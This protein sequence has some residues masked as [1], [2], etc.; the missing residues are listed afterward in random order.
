M[1]DYSFGYGGIGSGLDI[2]TMVTQLVAADR[3]PQDARLNKLEANAK[4]KLSGLGTVTSAFDA[5]KTALDTLQK[6]DALAA[7]T[8]TSSSSGGSSGQGGTDTVLAASVG[9]STPTGT[10]QVEVLSLASAH[11]LVGAGVETGTSF[12]AGTLQV[13]IGDASVDVEIAAGATLADVRSAINAAA[14]KHGLQA[15][16]LT[17]DDGQHLSL[18]SAKSGAASAITVSVLSGDDGLQAVV[19]GLQEKSPASDARVAIDGL[20]TTSSSN[21]VADAVPGLTLKLK[22]TGTSSVVVGADPSGSRAAVEGF[23]KAYNAALNAVATATSYNAETKTPSSLTGDAQMR[24]AVAQLRGVMGD[25]LGT[26]AAQGLDART[27]GLQTQGHPN[28]NGNLV[29]DAAKFDAAMTDNAAKIIA[30]FT[31]EDGVAARLNNVVKTYV[32]SDGSLTLRK[33]GLDDQ[34][35]D[36][37]RQR[38]ALELRMSAAAARYKAQFVALDT[39]MGQMTTT[40]NYLAQQI[41]ALAAQTQSR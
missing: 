18:A 33:K 36:V 1:A 34:V 15:S 5:L 27:L 6:A 22:G 40:S 3:A 35:K 13:G 14:G 24:G 7:R 9:K 8:V 26:L 30:A 20:V 31:G 21:T 17:S 2:S 41:S 37:T 39:L 19:D 16:L 38:E 23:V 10:Y 12:G 11:K 4:F 32:G 29:L 28:P 25:V